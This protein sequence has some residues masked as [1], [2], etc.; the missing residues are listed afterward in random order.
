MKIALISDIHGNYPAL[1]KVLDD[2]AANHVDQYVFVGDYI[3]DLPF[4]NEVTHLIMN[5]KNAHVIKGNKEGYLDTLA[6]ENQEDWIYD[7]MSCA[8]QTFRDLRQ[9]A[10]DYLVNLKEECF[11]PLDFGGKIYATHYLYGLEENTKAKLSSSNYYKKMVEQQFTHEEFL[12]MFNDVIKSDD[13]KRVIDTID[14]SVIV[15]GH[16]HLQSYGYCDGKLIINPGSCGL[17][18][19]FDNRVAYTILETSKNG[20]TVMERRVQ[21][22]IE[23]VISAS[24]RYALYDTARIWSELVFL[25]QRTGKNFSGRIFEIAYKIAAS[26]GE[27][28]RFFSNE[29]WK[30]SYKI[31]MEKI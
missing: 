9:E 29:T 13:F 6:K 14:A 12:L 10:F 3:F 2:A 18:Y 16:N 22:D 23:T 31:F 1:L 28:S 5:L 11:V 27:Q 4:S 15:F 20:F 19:D 30:E 26:K 17:P 25:T 21:Y 7:Q 24:K 8:Y